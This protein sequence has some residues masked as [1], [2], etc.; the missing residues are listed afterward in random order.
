MRRI[1]APL[2]PAST[3]PCLEENIPIFGLNSRAFT[4]RTKRSVVYTGNK[5]FYLMIV[6]VM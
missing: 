2:N 1:N 5:I 4:T 3:L 6:M